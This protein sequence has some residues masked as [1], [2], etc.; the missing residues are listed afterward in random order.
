MQEHRARKRFGQNFLSSPGV[1]A[2]IVLAI[3]P[4]RGDCMVEIGPGLAAM[5]APLQAALGH[6]HVVEIDRDLIARLKQNYTPEQLTI[7][8]G[9]A[10]EFDFGSL[11]E[12]DLRIV[13]NL[14]YNISTPILFHLSRFADKVKDKDLREIAGIAEDFGRRQPLAFLGLAAVA[15]LAASR[16]M[17]ASKPSVAT[18]SPTAP[19]INR[20][21][22][23]Y[24][25]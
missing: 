25:G 9:D 2:N 17:M 7:H 24:N 23:S 20:T 11:A 18:S 12:K 14:P 10:L 16:F 8:E 13:G 1:I 4:K 19:D 3:N 21:R 22:E 5:T 15:G 6:M